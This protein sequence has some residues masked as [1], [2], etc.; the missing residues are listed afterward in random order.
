MSFF[1]PPREKKSFFVFSLFH[2]EN[3]IIRHDTNQPP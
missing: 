3:M 2:R 1:A